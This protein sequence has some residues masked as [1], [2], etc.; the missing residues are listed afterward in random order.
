MSSPGPHF[1]NMASLLLSAC[2]TLPLC[3]VAQ[4]APSA[5]QAPPTTLHS[6][7]SLVL[8][9]VVVTEK[10]TPVQGLD[11]SRFH[12]REDGR[13]QVITSFEEHKAPAPRDLPGIPPLAPD[14]YT[15]RPDYPESTPANVLLLDALNTPM[16]DQ[17][18]ARQQMLD[19]LKRLPPGTPLAVFTLGSRLRIVQGLTSDRG[20]LSAALRDAGANPRPSPVLDTT[21]NQALS[22]ATADMAGFGASG[23]ATSAMQQFESDN[24]AMQTDQRVMLTLQAMQQLARYCSG[25]PTRKNLIWFSGSFPLTLDADISLDR[26][27]DATRNYSEELRETSHLLSAARVAVYPVDARGL[28][29]LPMADVNYSESASPQAAGSGGGPT[30][31]RHGTLASGTPGFARDNL[32]FMKQTQAEHASML[33]VATD[34]GGWAFFESNGLQASLDRI[35]RHGSNYYT[36]AYHS[37]AKQMDGGLRRI[38]V[39]VDGGKYQLAYRSG[40]YADDPAKVQAFRSTEPSLLATVAH[41]APDS[42]ELL[43]TVHLAHAHPE[44]GL[45]PGQDAAHPSRPLLPSSRKSYTLD[46]T[47]DPRDLAW[48]T[49]EDGSMIAQ[50]EFIAIAYGNDRKVLKRVDQ[51]FAFHL[52]REQSS[53]AMKSGIPRR[54]EVDLPPGPLSLRVAVHDLGS[55]RIGSAE[56]PVKVVNP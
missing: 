41:G 1:P 36:L 12:V 47:V 9:D 28:L 55:N 21:T 49:L 8:V 40:Y 2:W 18:Q 50:V 46:F 37:S 7:T 56:F 11:Q 13:D 10:G 23:Q 52:R 51:G 48:N 38:D 4:S 54:V 34:T 31:A 16:A 17:M 25:I 30:S 20:V 22:S 32:R 42:T 6:S 14:T 43:F 26:P 3:A 35:M 33:Q 29:T 39:R 15:N 24:L 44:S 19:Y 45:T 27:L 5:P 53:D